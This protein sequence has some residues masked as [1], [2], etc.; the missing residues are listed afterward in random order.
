MKKS[1]LFAALAIAATLVSCNKETAPVEL[2]PDSREGYVELTLSASVDADTK[3]VL[4]GK[5]VVWEV[6]EEL[7]VYT[8]NTF[9]SNKFTVVSVE[10]NEVMIS[11]SVPEGA[12][13]FIAVYPYGSAL[14]YNSGTV[15]MALPSEQT[16]GEG[17]VVAPD[18]LASVAYFTDASTKGQFKNVFS[19]LAF[20][21]SEAEDVDGAIFGSSM[22]KSSDNGNEITVEVSTGADP[23]V[24]N[25]LGGFAVTVSVPGGVKAGETYYAVV[26]PTEEVSGFY[27]GPSKGHKAAKRSS[28]K[29]FSLTRNNGFNLGDLVAEGAA[30]KFFQIADCY[31]L[32]EFLAEAASYSASDKV[33]VV[34]DIDMLDVDIATAESFAGIFEGNGF[35]IKNW[36]SECVALFNE[37][38]GEI[39]NLALASSC[40]LFGQLPVGPFG[41]IAKSVTGKVVN[42]QNN[43]D[44]KLSIVSDPATGEGEEAVS[45]ILGRQFGSI[46][47]RMPDHNAQLVECSN[48]GDIEISVEISEPMQGTLYLGGLV[49]HVGIPGEE[50]VTRLQ[51]CYNT[52]DFTVKSY[53][54]GDPAEDTKYLKTHFIGGVAGATGAN[55][56]SEEKQTGFTKYYGEIREC[57]NSGA[58]T[59]TWT[60]GTGGYFK[61]G[62]VIGYAEGSL[63]DC[64]NEGEVTF[65][66]SMELP[67]A[68]PSVGGVAGVVAGPALVSARDCENKGTVTIKGMFSNASAAYATGEAGTH[69][70]TGG[71]C[72]G[73]IGDQA[74]IVE[75][76]I[77]SGEVSVDA[78]MAVSAGST[79][80]F[81]GLAGLSYGAVKDCSN[82]GEVTASG[83]SK[84]FHVAGVVAYSYGNVE[85]CDNAKA[86]TGSHNVE[87][88]TE[89]RS[90]T[91]AN[92][93]G[94]VAYAA[95]TMEYVKDCTN[96]G[97]VVGTNFN[98]QGRL[99]G[100]VGIS[101]CDILGCTNSGAVS[102]ER[103]ESE[104]TSFTPLA[105]YVAGIVGR[106]NLKG[107]TISE[108]TNT[109]DVYADFGDKTKTSYVGGIC[110]AVS[111][112]ESYF[113]N[114]TNE[115]EVSLEDGSSATQQGGIVGH[116]EGICEITSCSNR[117]DVIFNGG[118]APRAAGIVGYMNKM[119]LMTFK[120]CV[121]D[122]DVTFNDIKDWASGYA[123]LGGISGYSGTP[124]AKAVFTYEGCVNNGTIE[125]KLNDPKWC[126]RIGGITGL[127]GASNN[128]NEEFKDCENHG[129]IISNSSI[130]GKN[131]LGALVSYCEK[132]STVTCDGFTNTGKLSATGGA[133]Y[134]GVLCGGSANANPFLNSSNFTNLY[135]SPETVVETGEDGKAALLVANSGKFTGEFSGEVAGTVK[136]GDTE[137]VADA[138]NLESLL[139]GNAVAT[140]T[141][142]VT[143]AE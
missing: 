87:A 9:G 36:S 128:H 76:C 32:K 112:G 31:D 12:N 40:D 131:V 50:V 126:C 71:G 95:N 35:Q 138:E 41:F 92:V 110:G 60:G 62:G 34:A 111:V 93:A 33:E 56:G 88:L 59:V 73:T 61:V 89:N 38:S 25:S 118:A 21:V 74:G 11:G 69:Y 82:K 120:D 132:Q 19:L 77:N 63:F 78:T 52:G 85:N 57:S 13:G 45:G 44:A 70:A 53:I 124:Q 99:A 49:G 67:N 98:S 96:T 29:S 15:R 135:I 97:D 2:T 141:I 136:V 22:E 101:Y 26:P 72:F 86:V 104:D 39:R 8:E 51:G 127:C 122:G 14:S 142:N 90:S 55:G 125:A 81:G 134:V 1:Y 58:V 3:A 123:Y 10:G 7:A 143:L 119:T 140:A 137:T 66:N 68:G 64:F 37:V 133:S 80:C 105:M 109:G 91:T 46:A 94:I 27:A 106:S 139:F 43:A 79:S 83:M 5:K 28:G 54:P 116:V 23:V 75:S 115:G 20:Q 113:D 17:Q 42:C 114:C 117:G 84:N 48:T 30:Y 108:C 6:G 47:G 102:V 18:A 103:Y 24:S 65:A 4:D 129:D 16:I 100:I 107:K 121:N 130:G